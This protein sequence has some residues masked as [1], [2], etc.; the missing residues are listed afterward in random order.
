MSRFDRAVLTLLRAPS[1]PLDVH[2]VED[3]TAHCRRIHFSAPE[4]LAGQA[5]A[6]TFWLRLWIPVGGQEVQRA[7]TVTEVRRDA[8]LFAADFVLHDT[9]GPASD[10]ARA[11]APGAKL[12]ATVYPGALFALPDPPPNGYLLLGDP[13]S[14]PAIN[15]IL[16]A[17]PE[18]VP[19]R[20]LLHRQHDDD[21][22]LTVH[23]RPNDSLEWT[24][25]TTTG[26][27]LSG[28]LDGWHAWVATETGVTRR[29]RATLHQRLPKAAVKARGYWIA[30]RP[31]GRS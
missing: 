4:L 17:L 13:A 27:A 18:T 30:G 6:P 22:K 9:P 31:M 5:I 14:L 26:E 24:D 11:A 10:W 15:E 12:R 1:Y 19:A 23:T 20:I 2:E 8:G 25:L 3:L 28:D 16:K 21:P 7:Y 29:L